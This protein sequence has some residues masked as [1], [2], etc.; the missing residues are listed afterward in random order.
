MKR[1]LRTLGTLLAGYVVLALF[2]VGV[3]GTLQ[4]AFGP[5]GGQGILRTFDSNGRAHETRLAIVDD[6]GTLWIQSAQHFR[7]WYDRLLLNPEVELPRNGEVRSYHAV[8]LDTPE[9][10]ARV[11]YLLKQR[12]AFRFYVI[13]ALLLFADV[14]P[15]RLDPAGA[16]PKAE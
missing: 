14:K 13:R 4:P 8:P 6:G 10:E 1:I 11:S 12:G 3:M 2:I 9:T 16:E 15:V 7:G 5:E